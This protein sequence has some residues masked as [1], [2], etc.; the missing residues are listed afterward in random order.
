MPAG[1]FKQRCLRLL[2]DVRTSGE[3]II[4][5]KRGVPVA[6]LAPLPAKDRHDWAGAMAGR[7]AIHGDLV[8]PAADREEWEALR[9]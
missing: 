1:E 2:E 6:R 5:T 3:T 4:I 9:G 7:G 8:A